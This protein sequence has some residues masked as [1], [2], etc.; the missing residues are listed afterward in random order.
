MAAT[1]K[2]Q[3]VPETRLSHGSQLRPLDGSDDRRLQRDGT[4]GIRA[5]Q[6]AFDRIDLNRQTGREDGKKEEEFLP[7]E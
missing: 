5:R 1:R 3:P 6:P 4:R 7:V 2:H